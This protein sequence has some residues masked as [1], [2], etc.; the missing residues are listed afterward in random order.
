M[1]GARFFLAYYTTAPYFD[2]TGAV[3]TG[4]NAPSSFATLIGMVGNPKPYHGG[5]ASRFR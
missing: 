4:S 5:Y 2:A 3:S 1:W